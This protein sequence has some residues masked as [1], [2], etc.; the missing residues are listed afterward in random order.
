MAFKDET[1]NIEHGVPKKVEFQNLEAEL[2]AIWEGAGDD[3]RSRRANARSL[4]LVI[5]TDRDELAHPLGKL[6]G[7]VITHNPARALVIRPEPTA[8]PHGIDAWISTH[9]VTRGENEQQ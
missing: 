9:C 2:K 6:V 8:Q 5:C 7:E 1:I 4:T 3:A